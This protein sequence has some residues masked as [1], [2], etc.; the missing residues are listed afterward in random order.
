MEGVVGIGVKFTA[1]QLA[2]GP[3][4]PGPLSSMQ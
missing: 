1:G 4:L 3:L 2:S